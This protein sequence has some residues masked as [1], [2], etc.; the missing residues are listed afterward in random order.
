M[1]S[2]EGA[3]CEIPVWINGS[4]K[5]MTGLTKRTT[6]DDIVYSLL[7]HEGLNA[8]EV[9]VDVHNH[10]I[11]EKWRKVERPLEGRAKIVKVW[12]AWGPEKR[13]VKF[14]IRKIQLSASGMGRSRRNRGQHRRRMATEFYDAEKIRGERVRQQNLED[15]LNM[16]LEQQCKLQ[17]QLNRI[18]KTDKEIENF[19]TNLH[20]NRMREKGINYLQDSYLQSLS[21]DSSG[22]E[23]A[24]PN[25]K[26]DDLETYLKVC[27]SI[28]QVEELIATENGKIDDLSLQIQL[29]NNGSIDSP[30]TSGSGD[31]DINEIKILRE[32]L[33]IATSVGEFQGKELNSVDKNV[34]NSDVELESKSR[35]YGRMVNELTAFDQATTAQQPDKL[36]ILPSHSIRPKPSIV[37][38]RAERR[39]IMS[40][41]VENV[42]SNNNRLSRF[43]P[44]NQK[45]SYPVIANR[46]NLVPPIGAASPIFS[47]SNWFVQSGDVTQREIV[48]RFPTDGSATGQSESKESVTESGNSE[49]RTTE[50]VHVIHNSKLNDSTEPQRNIPPDYNRISD[51]NPLTYNQRFGD[52]PKN[53]N[54]QQTFGIQFINRPVG[55]SVSTAPSK[56]QQ[57]QQTYYISENEQLNY[58][59]F[60]Y[61]KSRHLSLENL[62]S[63]PSLSLKEIDFHE[64]TPHSPARG[65]RHSPENGIPHSPASG[66]QHSPANC[67][68]HSPASGTQHSP[69]SSTQHSPPPRVSFS[70]DIQEQDHVTSMFNIFNSDRN[71]QR[72]EV[73]P[74]KSI[75]KN[76]RNDYYYPTGLTELINADKRQ[77]D[78][79]SN[80]DTGLSSLHS[81]EGSPVPNKSP[82]VLETLV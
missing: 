76:S 74:I 26:V 40:E 65:T 70:D 45:L 36:N 37:D 16:V 72:V 56:Y 66:T 75:L 55:G 4:E 51:N 2:D 17:D 60:G 57:L 44:Q 68:Q 82:P 38:T 43:A 63:H 10:M 13:H 48:R 77:F 78:D 27:E 33:R 32:K 47:R 31:C 54:Y 14:T 39:E 30:I 81:D 62:H 6:C 46:T 73:K 11:F 22:L 29:E 52:H 41:S 61:D 1:S 23:D 7:R 25:M 67:T 42:P 21:D 71:I 50:S 5:L 3:G 12:K 15:L 80:S 35:Y 58:S 34:L 28:I 79:D 69:A 19:E 24:L 64:S 49:S 18:Q 53:S 59:T 9:D 20:V 8:D